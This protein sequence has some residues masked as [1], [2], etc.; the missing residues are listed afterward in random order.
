MVLT[1][2]VSYMYRLDWHFPSSAHGVFIFSFTLLVVG[3]IVDMAEIK[4]NT[5]KDKVVNGPKKASTLGKKPVS[6]QKEKDNSKVLEILR[7]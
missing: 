3:C 2:F 7:K 1:F 5:L 4:S 6:S